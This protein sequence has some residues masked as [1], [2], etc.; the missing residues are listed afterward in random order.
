MA[1]RQQ[2][3]DRSIGTGLPRAERTTA[4][5]PG[6]GG[7]ARRNPWLAAALVAVSILFLVPFL[8]LLAASLKVR[9]EVFG[10]EL[11]PDPFA[12]S[13]YS[14]VW[15]IAP[16]LRWFFNSVLVGALAAGS[17]VISSALVA[18]GFA[19]FRFRGRGVLFGLVLATMMLPG[20]V[21]MIPTFLIWDYLGWTNTQVPLWAHNLFGSAFYTFMLRQFFLTIPRDLFEA[22]RVDGAN[23]LQVWWR[24]AMPLSKPALIVVALFEFKASWTD[25][26]RP[27]IYLSDEAQFTLPLGLKTLLDQ[28]GAHGIQAWELVM[29]A[30]V[31]STVPMLVLFFIAQRHFVEGISTTG[32]K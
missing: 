5:M 19:Y 25:L 6:P 16:V 13:N 11:L 15:K 7:E 9:S 2:G 23:Y 14:Q 28:F 21:T 10:P 24:I 20:A 22:A 3:L 30:S 31:I 1:V 18:F 17:V 27:L 4:A 8:W 26:L 32:I 29:A 12:W